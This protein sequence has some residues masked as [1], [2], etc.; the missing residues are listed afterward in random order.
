LNDLRT[1]KDV[2]QSNF[3]NPGTVLGGVGADF[4]ILPQ[5]RLATN[6]N[7]LWFANTEVLELLRQQ[8]GIARDIGWDLSTAVTWRPK[9]TQNIVLRLSGAI[10]VPGEGMRDLFGNTS[11][12]SNYFSVLGNVIVNF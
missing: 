3:V 5:L 6:A 9:A 4:D 1:S 12:D 7:H 8:G 10:L 2:G 11:H